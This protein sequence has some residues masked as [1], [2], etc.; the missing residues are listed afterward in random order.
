M[1]QGSGWLSR[2]RRLLDEAGGDCVERGYL[3]L[4][5]GLSAIDAGEPERAS[6]AFALAGACGER[7]GDRD[8]VAL[9]RHGQGR[10]LIRCGRA[11]EGVRLLDE[12]MVAVTTGE[13][14]PIVAG[15]VYCSVISGC[16][17]IFDWRRAAEWTGALA[18]WCSA[19]PDLVAYRGQCLL[20]RSEV[21]QL[22]GEWTAALDEARRACRRLSEPE[23]QPGLAAA[24]YQVGELY[25]LRGESSEAD[26]AYREA[27][28]LGRRPLPGLALLRLAQGDAAAAV[29]ALTVALE[30]AEAPRARARLLPAMVEAALAAREVAAARRAAEEL[31]AI[32]AEL[33]APYLRGAA[34]HAKGAVLLAEDRPRE[35]LD[36]LRQAERCWQQ[37][38]AAYDAARTRLLL[39]EACRALGD[40]GGADFELEAARAC[41][42]RLGAAPELARVAARA[43]HG[44]SGREVEVLRLVAGGRT[45]RAIAAALGIS[46][47]TVARHLSN[48]FV[49]LGVSSRTAATAW[50][51]EHTLV[52]RAA[53]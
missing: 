49:K 4:P 9:A 15:E 45:N 18:R 42:V 39:A 43:A 41:F 16:Q 26:A 1:A 14:S 33:R 21:L 31:I 12:A 30:A 48:I 46:E 11:A 53:T 20:R 5:D 3:L 17:E 25:R 40:A 23:T 22:Q 29:S 52:R 2:A 24:W 44:L 8:L 50:A 36:P 6:A 38:D 19:Q 10:A 7:F 37:T 35:A 34:A 13:V 47:K 32:A 51:Y 27:A 28:R